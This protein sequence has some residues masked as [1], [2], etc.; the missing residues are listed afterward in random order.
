MSCSYHTLSCVTL[1]PPQR[2]VEA[3]V[4]DLASRGVRSL[5][6][7][8]TNAEGAWTMMGILSFLDPPRYTDS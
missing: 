4:V 2:A 1:G 3:S 6:V 7:A 5:A 8:R